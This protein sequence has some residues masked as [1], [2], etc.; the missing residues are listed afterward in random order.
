MVNIRR[1]FPGL[2]CLVPALFLAFCTPPETIRPAVET[3]PQRPV[4]IFNG[5]TLVY[6]IS[7]AD[8]GERSRFGEA[9]GRFLTDRQFSADRYD[10]AGV[11]TVLRILPSK[12]KAEDS[13]VRPEQV[14][15]AIPADTAPPAFGGPLRLYYPRGLLD[16]P[17]A[18]LV[19]AAPF[20]RGDSGGGYFTTVNSSPAAVTLRLARKTVNGAGKTLNALDIIEL[21]TRWVKERPAEGLALFRFC[22]GLAKYLRGEEAIILGLSAPDKNS[23]QIRF[24]PPDPQAQERLRSARLL[25]AAFKLGG[26]ALSAAKG[27]DHVLAANPSADEKPFVKELTVRCGGDPNPL[28]SFSLGRYDAVMLWSAK[29]IDYGRRMLM[30]NSTCSLVGRDRYFV[31]CALEDPA[32]RALVRSALSGKELLDNFVKAEG[33]LIPAVESDRASESPQQETAGPSIAGPVTILFRKDDAVSKIIA[34]RLLAAMSRAG[35]QGSL[36][37]GGGK[38]YENALVNHGYACAVGW[39]P[40]SVLADTSEKLRL[41]SIFFNDEPDEDRRIRE[42]REIPLFSI[43]WYLLAKNRIGLYKGKFSG[44]YVKQ[45]NR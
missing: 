24:S 16:Y 10:S 7:F 17:A 27:N 21:W 5:D 9:F 12:L 32:A 30:K 35:V 11:L 22:D 31:A 34:E 25:P 41:A 20:G 43:D 4:K 42:N 37:A 36:A 23:I 44:L 14:P 13:A 40:E 18:A 19:D 3:L 28:L 15:A 33:A 29:D 2:L 6:Q 38:E 39:A 26:Y 1:P 45:E 8:T